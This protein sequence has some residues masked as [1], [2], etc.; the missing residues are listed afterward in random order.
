MSS[1]MSHTFEVCNSAFSSIK[2]I[3]T[4]ENIITG[5]I[6]CNEVWKT[7]YTNSDFYI[8]KNTLV[9]RDEIVAR[10]I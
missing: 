10:E 6:D 5:I 7:N 2:W 8:F 9:C 1:K 3:D 4:A